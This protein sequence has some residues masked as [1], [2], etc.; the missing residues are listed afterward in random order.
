MKECFKFK[1]QR[2]EGFRISLAELRPKLAVANGMLLILAVG[3][4]GMRDDYLICFSYLTWSLFWY[5]IPML[6]RWGIRIWRYPLILIDMLVTGY[7]LTRTGGLNS[8]LSF[9]LFLPIMVAIVRCRLPGILVWSSIMALFLTGAAYYSETLSFGVLLTKIAYLYLAGIIGGLLVQKTHIAT[10][11][12]S[13]DLVQ[14]NICLQKLNSFSQ[15]VSSSSDLDGIFNQI[16]KVAQQ[17]NPNIL[18]A[19]ALFDESGQL[20]IWDSSWEEEWLSNYESHPLTT[21]SITLAPILVFKRPLLCSDINKHKE[22]VRIFEGLPVQALFA[23]PIV[24]A[25]EVA[26]ALMVT[27]SNSQSL[28]ESDIQIMNNITTQAGVALQN[29]ASLN[30][31]KNQADTDGLTGLYNRRYF[32]EKLVELVNRAREDGSCLSLIMI[33]VDN[34]KKYNDTYGHPAGDQLLKTIA[35]VV[36][37]AV[38][39]GDIITRYGGE[40]IAVILA[41]TDKETALQIAERIRISVANIPTGKVQTPVTISLGVGTMPEHAKDCAGLIEFADQSLYYSKQSGKNRV[42]CGFYY[43]SSIVVRN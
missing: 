9:F 11:A 34:F 25:G 32:N 3:T 36:N 24:V 41:H 42:S 43:R 27:T 12:V 5:L 29:I 35:L 26:G 8:E 7:M 40:E 37:D 22:L 33:D 39:D 30:E 15:E 4:E 2:N 18:V 28:P 21:D 10:G 14:L 17:N 20:K 16:I 38:R 13:E 23:F 19:I 31:V 1:S 6:S